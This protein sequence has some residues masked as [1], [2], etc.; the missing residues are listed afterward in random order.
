MNI[1]KKISAIILLSSLSISVVYAQT[2]DVITKSFDTNA[3]NV[4]GVLVGLL[5]FVIGGLGTYI[6]VQDKKITRLN[7]YIRDS[8]KESLNVLNE[9][10]KKIGEVST[11]LQ[12][13]DNN[14]KSNYD[15]IFT[16]VDKSL[17]N[18]KEFIRDK[19]STK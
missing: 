2:P 17:D 15:H 4:Y 18:F 3:T 12:I 9:L 6:I 19:V 1:I 14:V 16:T 5:V 10:T 13:M 11:S 8:D 7:D